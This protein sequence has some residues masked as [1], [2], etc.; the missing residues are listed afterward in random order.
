MFCRR[1]WDIAAAVARNPLSTLSAPNFQKYCINDATNC[2]GSTGWSGTYQN[3]LT[4]NDTPLYNQFSNN[5]LA[6]STS[7][8]SDQ[9]WLML[10]NTEDAAFGGMKASFTQ[11]ANLQTNNIAFTTL[12]CP[13]CGSNAGAPLMTEDGYSWGDHPPHNLYAYPVALSL[14]NGG[15]TWT[16]TPNSIGGYRSGQFLLAYTLVPPSNTMNQRFLITRSVTVFAGLA[17]APD[18]Q[19]GVDMARWL[20]SAHDQRYS[21]TQPPVWNPWPTTTLEKDLKAYLVTVS[22]SRGQTLTKIVECVN[23]TWPANHP[24]ILVTNG[25]CDTGYSELTIAGYVFPTQPT[26]ISTVQIFRCLIDPN[27]NDLGKGT[28]FVSTDPS[29]TEAGAIPNGKPEWALGYALTK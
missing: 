29:C 18:P 26:N 3:G 7:Y 21:S 14:A 9:G 12:P 5:K 19:V 8:W 6:S 23:N 2:P 1:P 27:S 11:L 4:G 17:T 13:Q 16:L 15:R 20:D 10:L 24:D 28:H 25:S 22:H